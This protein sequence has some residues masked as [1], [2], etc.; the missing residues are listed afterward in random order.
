MPDPLQERSL[1]QWVRCYRPQQRLGSLRHLGNGVRKFQVRSI[2]PGLGMTFPHSTTVH[3]VSYGR[4]HRSAIQMLMQHPTLLSGNELILDH[5]VTGALAHVS[6]STHC[7]N[8]QLRGKSSRIHSR[9]ATHALESPP[10]R[11]Q[12][13]DSSQRPSFVPSLPSSPLSEVGPILIVSKSDPPGRK[14]RELSIRRKFSQTLRT[15]SRSPQHC[16]GD[17]HYPIRY[18]RIQSWSRAPNCC[19]YGIWIATKHVSNIIYWTS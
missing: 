16:P 7:K 11:H 9:L 2:I 17:H 6:K 4:L 19:G 14:I 8:P 5:E 18:T 15:V 1:L 10:D 3:Y 13:K 12:S